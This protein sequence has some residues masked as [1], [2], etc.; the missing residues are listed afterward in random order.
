[1][2]QMEQA[3]LTALESKFGVIIQ[4][5][6]PEGA[7]RL[8]YTTKKK[9]EQAGYENLANLSLVTSPHSKAEYLIIKRANSNGT[10]ET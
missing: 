7:K 9:M 4:T 2:K 5:D 6:N 10:K 3:I 1:M 8:F